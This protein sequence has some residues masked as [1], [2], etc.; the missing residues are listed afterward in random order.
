M[1]HTRWHFQLIVVTEQNPNC[2]V[3]ALDSQNSS[4]TNVHEGFCTQ[5][6]ALSEANKYLNLIQR[7]PV[8]PYKIISHS[9]FTYK[10]MWSDMPGDHELTE[11][12]EIINGLSVGKPKITYPKS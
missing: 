7:N 5:I 3:I 4:R 2:A 8:K 9:I 6:S 1:I 10:C 11:V 12:L